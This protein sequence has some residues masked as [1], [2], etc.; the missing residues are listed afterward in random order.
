MDAKR[1]DEPG[2]QEG[3]TTVERTTD[4]ELVT[5]RSFNGPARLVYEAWTR[6]ELLKRWWAPKSTGL[7][8]RACDA[9]VRVGG[10]Y[11]F[12]FSHP[13]SPQPM[14]FFGRYLEV[15]PHARLVW[16]NDESGDGPVT[17]VS[18]EEKG[19]RTL[20]VMREVFPSAEALVR[21]AAGMEGTEGGMPESFS[22]LDGLLPSLRGNAG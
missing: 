6:P 10:G 2:F 16:T 22:Q 15:V 9:D 19:G 17:T 14:V 18:F 5:T 8:L 11:R 21:A 1:G 13:A 7:V 12:E 20:V 4:R 3:R